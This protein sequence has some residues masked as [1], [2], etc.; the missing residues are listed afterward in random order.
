MAAVVTDL[1]ASLALFQYLETPAGSV[2]MNVDGSSTPVEFHFASHELSHITR[3]NWTHFDNAADDIDGFFSIAALTNGCTIQ[4]R[5]ADG[6]VLQHFG[7]D[8]VPLKRSVDFAAL[9][10]VDVRSDSGGSVSA[11]AVRWTIEAVG[12]ELLLRPSQAFVFTVRD[13]L[14][15]LTQFRAMAQGVIVHNPIHAGGPDA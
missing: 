2:D 9:A 14:T 7:T 15:A 12:E 1:Q 6:T 4:V 5:A 3:I 10:G 8:K 13:N 11:S